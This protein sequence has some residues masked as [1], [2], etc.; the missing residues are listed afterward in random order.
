MKRTRTYLDTSTIS[1]YVADGVTADTAIGAKR[2]D[3]RQFWQIAKHTTT[4]LTTQ[5]AVT[6][7]GE[8][9]GR[10]VRRRLAALKGVKVVAEPAKARRLAAEYARALGRD[11]DDFD[12]RHIAAA[13]VLGAK[14]LVTWDMRSMDKR[15]ILLV[16]GL[17]LRHG[18]SPIAMMS[19]RDAITLLS[20]VPRSNPAPRSSRRQVIGGLV[21]VPVKVPRYIQTIVSKIRQRRKLSAGR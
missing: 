19:P 6:E 4:L 9:H 7:A 17:S 13:T 8:G 20:G 11:A 3:T 14:I 5:L 21:F 10:Q 12:L 1:V 2:V 18:Y 15:T 16:T